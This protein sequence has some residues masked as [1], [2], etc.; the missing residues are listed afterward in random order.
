MTVTPETCPELGIEVPVGA[1]DKELRK[2]WEQDDAQTNASLMNLAIYCEREGSLVENSRIIQKLTS[3]HACRAILVEI[4]KRTTEASLRAWITAHCHLSGGKKSICCEQVAFHLTGRVTGRFRNTVFSHLNSDLPLIFWWQG[5]LSDVFTERLVAVMDRL[6]I[7]SS[8]WSDPAAAF[9]IIDDATQANGD[10]ILQDLAWTR[11]WQFRVGIAG[12]FDDPVAQAAL[13]AVDCVEIIH[14]PDHRNSA[15]QVLAWLGVQAG[16]EQTSPSADGFVFRAKAGGKVNARLL[17]D[18]SSAPLGKVE[19]SS[20]HVTVRV[21]RDAGASHVS[22]QI[23]SDGYLA[24][25]LSPADPDVD[26][27]LVGLQLSRGG[28]NSL[29]QKILPRFRAMLG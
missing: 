29:Y 6:I 16:W 14:H 25:S 4:N 20:G 28:K 15:L 21:N 19:I 12:L 1:I 10:L 24:N 26:A 23:Q 17:S 11:S 5:E 8:S 27:E 3:E 22:R 13:P 9:S 7:D 2:L 18:P